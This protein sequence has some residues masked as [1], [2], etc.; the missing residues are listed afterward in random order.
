[1]HHSNIVP[2]WCDNSLHV[3]KKRQ[4]KYII[5]FNGAVIRKPTV[6]SFLG[7]RDRHIMLFKLPK[8]L[9]LNSH[10]C[11]LLFFQNQPIILNV[12]RIYS[13]R[14]QSSNLSYTRE[15]SRMRL[16]LSLRAGSTVCGSN[17]LACETEHLFPTGEEEFVWIFL[18]L[19]KSDCVGAH[20]W[21]KMLIAGW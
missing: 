9:F 17:F 13:T 11:C 20:N 16:L 10:D 2:K 4:L 15:S 19:L 21:S 5:F 12:K 8:I 6:G 1:M 3:L 14:K 7:T 18:F